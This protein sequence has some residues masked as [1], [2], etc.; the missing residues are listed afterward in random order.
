MR[1]LP[2]YMIVEYPLGGGITIRENDTNDLVYFF[3]IVYC[4]PR[5]R[6]LLRR[7]L[8]CSTSR[9]VDDRDELKKVFHSLTCGAHHFSNICLNFTFSWEFE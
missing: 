7:S 3:V 4:V 5:V 8:F 2:S 1:M 9:R 6:R